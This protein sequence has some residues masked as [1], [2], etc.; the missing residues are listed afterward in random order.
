MAWQNLETHVQSYKLHDNQNFRIA[1]SNCKKRHLVYVV[2]D[3][4]KGCD[5]Q[6]MEY[7]E[8]NIIGTEYLA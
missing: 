1:Y 8:T 6:S 2:I 7:T 3:E 5:L 4:H